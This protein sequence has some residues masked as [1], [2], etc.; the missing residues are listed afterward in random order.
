[1]KDYDEL[2]ELWARAHSAGS[3]IKYVRNLMVFKE[4]AKLEP[5]KTLDAG[6]GTGEYSIFLAKRGHEVTA[7]DP[8]SFALKGLMEKGGR[9]LGITVQENTFDGFH[10]NIEFDN[11]ISIEVFEHLSDDQSAI[12]K[13]YSLLR[14]GGALVIS[15]PARPFLFS[16]AD[17]ISGHYRRYL[18]NDFV[19]LLSGAGLK[20]IR[21]KSYGFPVLF[22]YSLVRKMFL[23]RL[24]INYFSSSSRE[25]KKQVTYLTSLYP[26][27]L[28]LD[29][30]NIPFGGIGYVAVCKK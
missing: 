21:V 27:V 26:Y 4:L 28:G 9:E 23:D 29:R 5:G 11:I 24:L 16:E 25:P 18:C 19:K 6:C 8:S 20:D 14:Q 15:V 1:M 12:Q 7:F 30:L 3:P 10:S 17:R 22:L 13:C 2:H